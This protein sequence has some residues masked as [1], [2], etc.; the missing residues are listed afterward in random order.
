MLAGRAYRVVAPDPAAAV[1]EARRLHPN[2]ITLDLLMPE[3]SG[4]DILRELRSDPAT[5]DIP[6][7]SLSVVDAADA[8][9]DVDG[10]LTK[11]LKK[12]QLLRKLDELEKAAAARS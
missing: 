10:H 12:G 9:K 7:I 5:R 8:P 11:P 2:V 1:S 4:A 3:R 6:V